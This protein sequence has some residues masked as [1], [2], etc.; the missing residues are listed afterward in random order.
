MAPRW[1]CVAVH[2]QNSVTGERCS[3]CPGNS[4]Q[5]LTKYGQNIH[6]FTN[7][8][9]AP[10]VCQLP[11]KS[12]VNRDPRPPRGAS[13]LRGDR[14]EGALPIYSGRDATGAHILQTETMCLC[15]YV[16]HPTFHRRDPQREHTHP[17]PRT[18]RVEKRDSLRNCWKELKR[19]RPLQK[20]SRENFKKVTG[21][22]SRTH[23]KTGV[24]QIT[25]PQQKN[26]DEALPLLP[27]QNRHWPRS[28]TSFWANTCSSNPHSF[29]L[30]C[31]ASV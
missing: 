1:G 9:W 24:R 3:Q 14:P 13:G 27:I 10:C 11:S 21:M 29:T 31:Y 30:P 12:L 20:C 19:N 5:R 17:A 26:R 7:S 4:Q 23:W 6:L 8:Y 22:E 25:E 18:K 28:R 16:L 2:R 15:A